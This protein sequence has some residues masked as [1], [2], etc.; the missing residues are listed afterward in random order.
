[1]WLQNQNSYLPFDLV[2]KYKNSWEKNLII[3]HDHDQIAFGEKNNKQ[4][5][6]L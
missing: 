4:N 2:C 5:Q 3:F 1:M 6:I